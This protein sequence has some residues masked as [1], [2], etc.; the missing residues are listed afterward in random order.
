[1]THVKKYIFVKVG[2]G[3]DRIRENDKQ[4]DEFTWF[5][6]NYQFGI[7]KYLTNSDI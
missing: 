1:M 5:N 7:I 2:S 3:S 4:I 6:L